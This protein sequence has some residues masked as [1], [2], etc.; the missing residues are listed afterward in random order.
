MKI[1]LKSLKIDKKDRFLLK[2]YPWYL[3]YQGYI[4]A[5]LKAKKHLKIHNQ[6]G[7]LLHRLIVNAPKGSIVDHING[8]R[9]DNRRKNLRIVNRTQHCLNKQVQSNNKLGVKGVDFHN[10]KYRVVKVIKGKQKLI[11]HFHALKE[12]EKASIEADKQFFGKYSRFWGK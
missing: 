3:G 4:T 8:N 9:L 12:A 5:R 6:Q 7:I 2:E 10:N 1:W 11:G